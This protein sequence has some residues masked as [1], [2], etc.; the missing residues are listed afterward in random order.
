MTNFSVMLKPQKIW[1]YQRTRR[2]LHFGLATCFL[3]FG[4]IIQTHATIVVIAPH[5]DDAEA[6]C[7]GLI[8]N[9]IESGEDVIILTMTGG[10]LGIYG[11]NKKEALAIRT[12][13][14]RKGANI[15]GAK[16]EF[17]G[18]IDASLSVDS[19]GLAKLK[20]ILLRINPTVVLAPWPLDVHADHQASGLLAWRAFQD[21]LFTFELYFYETSNE[22]HTMSFQFFPSDYVDITK[23]MAKKEEAVFQHK[24]Q[25]PENWFQMYEVM[26][27]FR[28]YEADVTY[29]EG[30][31]KARNS[32][33]MGGRSAAVCKTLF[34][35]E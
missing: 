23:V 22:P 29:A 25:S 11:K 20:K 34:R 10:E 1:N 27:G 14:A 9:S 3:I 30:Y 33:G 13:E 5:P 4:F 31:L 15:L 7:G 17:F 28:G 32:S 16:V 24:S 8:L 2:F 18:E 21:K 35:K 19:A 12:E 26:A 6:S